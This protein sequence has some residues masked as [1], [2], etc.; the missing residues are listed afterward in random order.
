MLGDPNKIEIRLIS[1]AERGPTIQS[2]EVDM[3]VRTV[4]WTTSRDSQWGNYA[5]TMFFDGQGFLVNKDLGISSALEL[6]AAQVSCVTQGTTTELNLAD[7]S[8][9]NNLNIEVRSRSRTP[10]P[11]SAAYRKRTVRRIHQRP[12]AVGRARFG[13]FGPR[14]AYH[15]AGDHFGRASRPGGPARRRPVVRYS[16]DRHGHTDLCRGLRCGFRQRSQ[17]SYRRHQG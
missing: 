15:P 13:L 16:Q 17:R 10:T 6:K 7:F 2:G 9:Q 12:L 8:S 11:S 14:R 4:T 3:L 5:Q 1:A